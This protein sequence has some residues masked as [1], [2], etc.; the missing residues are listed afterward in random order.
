[1]NSGELPLNTRRKVI[2]AACAGD[3]APIEGNSDATASTTKLIPAN[4]DRTNLGSR[5]FIELAGF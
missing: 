2:L 1:M 5:I 4:R 3:A